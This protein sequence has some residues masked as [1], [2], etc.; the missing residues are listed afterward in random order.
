MGMYPL[1]K[2]SEELGY[3]VSGSDRAR[4]KFFELEEARGAEV[5]LGHRR[6]NSEGCDLLV[7]SLALDS[8]NPEIL[9]AEERGVPCISRAEYLGVIMR[10]YKNR[11]GISGTHGK[12]TTTAML[13]AIFKKQLANHTTV[14]GASLPDTGLPYRIGGRD[15]LIY[16]ACEYKDSFLCF[17]PTVSV[18]LNLELDHTDYFE[19][20]AHIQDSFLEAINGSPLSIVSADSPSL[21]ALIPKAAGRVV[22]FG[23]SEDADY[24]VERVSQKR[25]KCKLKFTYRGILLLE[26]ALSVP[27]RHNEL[28]ACAAVSAACELGIPQGDIR[29]ALEEF[30]GIERRLEYICRFGGAAVYYD[31]A[32]HPT[33]ISCSLS[34]VR[35]LVHGKITVLFKPHTY[36]R[37]ASL[38]QEFAEALSAADRVFILE[39]D[40]IREAQIPGVTGEVLAAHIGAHA[41]YIREENALSALKSTQSDAIIIMGAANLENVKKEIMKNGENK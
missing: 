29:A 13:D 12:S 19:G 6:E 4:G 11:I 38:M 33:E 36:S 25:G 24:R 22:K 28:N 20:L 41:E 27:G 26:A 14:I 1:Y 40:A 2:L 8:A 32:H 3:R 37:T 21:C 16:E 23:A 35:E 18:F 30:S 17:S 39:I 10:G 7:Y 34:A 15:T 9:S 31:Y 5:Y